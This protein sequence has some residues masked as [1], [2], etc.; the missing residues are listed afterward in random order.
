MGFTSEIRGA[1]ARE[2][3]EADFKKNLKLLDNSNEL[4]KQF[5]EST[6]T[7]NFKNIGS[8]G[9]V[10]FVKG[11]REGEAART[12]SKANP[13]LASVAVET[14]RFLQAM[15]REAL[16][17]PDRNLK[18]IADTE[19]EIRSTLPNL[20]SKLNASEI[21]AE[22]GKDKNTKE[23]VVKIEKSK[24]KL[25]KYF[26]YAVGAIAVSGTI[27][28]A[29]NTLAEIRAGCVYFKTHNQTTV[30][31]K[32]IKCSCSYPTVGS[33]MSACGS[34]PT[35]FPHSDCTCTPTSPQCLKCTASRES[36]N[37]KQNYDPVILNSNEVIRCVPKSVTAT[38]A[39]LY[40]EL[41]RSV[42]G[43]I[44]SLGSILKYVVYAC[45]AL[46]CAYLIFKLVGGKEK[47]IEIA[48]PNDPYFT[49]TT[50]GA[51]RIS[52]ASQ[53]QPVVIG[54]GRR[55]QRVE[56]LGP[57][58]VRFHPNITEEDEVDIVDQFQEALNVFKEQ[59]RSIENLKTELKNV[60][61]TELK[62]YGVQ[63]QQTNSQ[64]K[65]LSD[66]FQIRDQVSM[67]KDV[68]TIKSMVFQS[69]QPFVNRIGT[70]PNNSTIPQ[71]TYSDSLI[72]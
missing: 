52:S 51:K 11:L 55:R 3:I 39:D 5:L 68:D 37:D 59:S 38:I 71:I 64:L 32:I 41:P 36:P 61:S 72:V 47:P 9:T 2:A 25:G 54:G 18:K 30:G 14:N 26:L 49:T 45:I 60:L 28:S 42:I 56:Y 70:V 43:S 69:P 15:D 40:N 31:C 16:E 33:G 1:W 57:N 20:D 19:N 34:L 22:I 21:E 23:M 29:L 24:N 8:M 6:E 44:S 53:L 17:M 58:G 62:D 7:V 46:G 35:K 63:I 13:A 66:Y 27:Y 65:R 4:I 50:R 10:D 48:N 67:S 12:I